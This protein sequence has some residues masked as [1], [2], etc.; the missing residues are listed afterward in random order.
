MAQKLFI[1]KW[2]PIQRFRLWNFFVP[3]MP[4]AHLCEWCQYWFI[5]IQKSHRNIRGILWFK[6]IRLNPIE[7]HFLRNKKIIECDHLDQDHRV[8]NMTKTCAVV[9]AA[10]C[11]YRL[12]CVYSP[13]KFDRNWILWSELICHWANLWLANEVALL[14]I[15]FIVC[16]SDGRAMVGFFSTFALLPTVN[17]SKLN[18]LSCFCACCDCEKESAIWLS[19]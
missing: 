7:T 11:P 9:A 3:I 6:F 13:K 1:S 16:P 18:Q 10:F 12:L 17:V 2:K 4:C 8:V 14:E 5:D 19:M 15:V